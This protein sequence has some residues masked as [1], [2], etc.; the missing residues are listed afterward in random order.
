MKIILFIRV[1]ITGGI[2]L[3]ACLSAGQTL[4]AN[5]DEMVL[6]PTGRFIMGSGQEDG[7]AGPD[8][9]VDEE[10][11][12]EVYLKAYYIDKYEVTIGEYKKFLVAT[13]GKWFGDTNFQEE[14]LPEKLFNPPSWDNY[15]VNYMSWYDADTYCRWKGKRLPTEAEWEK[16]ARGTDGRKW[17]WGNKFD[18]QKALVEESSEGWTAP[19]GSHPEDKSP[20][21]LYD[22][23]GNLSEWTSSFYLPYPGNKIN[24]GR[25]SE[26]AYVLKGGSF[27]YFGKMYGRPAARSF[28]YPAYN[29]RMFGIR[30]AKDVH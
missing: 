28:A 6:I 7:E 26:N 15:P 1:I 10:P 25:Y 22:V 20:Y 16:A 12:H 21:G 30:C 5:M 18:R 9:G 4:Q 19:V 14:Y 3:L 11:R 2:L 8:Y 23:A 13:G 29:H 27:L 24:D 17:P